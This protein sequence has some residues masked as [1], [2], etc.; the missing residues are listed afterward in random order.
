[1]NSMLNL[2]YPT[3]NFE[4]ICIDDWENIKI[5]DCCL[6]SFSEIKRQ[7]KLSSLEF[8]RC[9]FKEGCD[10]QIFNEMTNLSTIK[11]IRSESLSICDFDNNHNL[12][13]LI[14]TNSDLQLELSNLN[15]LEYLHIELGVLSHMAV[16]LKNL[17]IL[18]ILVKVDNLDLSG[19]PNLEELVI[20]QPISLTYLNNM[21]KLEKFD[22]IRYKDK[23]IKTTHTKFIIYKKRIINIRP[24]IEFSFLKRKITEIWNLFFCHKMDKFSFNR[25]SYLSQ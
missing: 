17:K 1:M 20:D 22:R 11:I 18:E 25:L 16:K 5:K 21:Y 4:D 13:T 7:K 8:K 3:S 10:F 6:T 19:F 24:E 2:R 23:V 9:T 12:K 15:N 14:L